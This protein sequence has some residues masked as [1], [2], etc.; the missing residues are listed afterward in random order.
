MRY[1]ISEEVKPL[2][3][4]LY[5]EGSSAQEI[6][7]QLSIP[8]STRAIQR[9][10]KSHGIMRSISEAYNLAIKKGR[11]VY[12]KL[13]EELKAKRT[14]IPSA[15]RFYVLQRDGFKCV[16][17]GATSKLARLEVDHIN[18][19]PKHTTEDNLHTTCDLCNKGKARINR[20]TLNGSYEDKLKSTTIR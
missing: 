1:S 19:N 15:L 4:S 11:M 8:Q 13:P 2:I 14:K 10:V 16:F 9:L 20:I 12:T 17:C 7:E 6:K 18:N 3:I 5:K